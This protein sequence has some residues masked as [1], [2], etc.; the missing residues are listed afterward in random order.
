MNTRDSYFPYLLDEFKSTYQ[1]TTSKQRK[2]LELYF[3]QKETNI[4][5][6]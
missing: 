4:N 1:Q 2:P 5:D 3:F 6:A